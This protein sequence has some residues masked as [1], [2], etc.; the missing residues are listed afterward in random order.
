VCCWCWW[1]AA[2]S[3]RP[4]EEQDSSTGRPFRWNKLKGSAVRGG[5]G[6]T[7]VSEVVWLRCN[8]ALN[9]VCCVRMWVHKARSAVAGRAGGSLVQVQTACCGCKPQAWRSEWSC[10]VVPHIMCRERTHLTSPTSHPG[11][12]SLR[13]AP[14]RHAPTPCNHGALSAGVT[15]C[16][17]RDVDGYAHISCRS[18]GRFNEGG[19]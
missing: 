11:L 3:W 1:T 13:V 7:V 9:L 2:C 18:R 15:A 19:A 4:S 6:N 14:R 8:A 16:M 12:L 5:V 10:Y 17:L